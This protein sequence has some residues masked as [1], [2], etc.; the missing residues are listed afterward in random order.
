MSQNGKSYCTLRAAIPQKFHNKYFWKDCSIQSSASVYQCLSVHFCI[1]SISIITLNLSN[2][3]S[4]LQIFFFMIKIL[5]H[6]TFFWSF[7]PNIFSNRYRKN[8]QFNGDGQKQT[9][10]LIPSRTALL[11]PN[12][13]FSSARH[14]QQTCQIQAN[15]LHLSYVKLDFAR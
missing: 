12:L 4:F 14:R 6:D 7:Y 9:K 1:N 13:L 2:K 11:S 3:K 10:I 15:K 8:F 5:F